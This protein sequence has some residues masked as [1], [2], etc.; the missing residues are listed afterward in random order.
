MNIS[1]K[2]I[3]FYDQFDDLSSNEVA[4]LLK[5]FPKGIIAVDLETTGLSPLVDKIIELS[6]IKVTAAGISTYST[7]INPRIEIPEYTIQ[8]HGITDEMVKD[9]P[10]EEDV[11]GSFIDFCE[12]LPLIGHNAKFDTGFLAFAMGRHQLDLPTS[13]VYCSC[14]M[15]KKAFPNT[16]NHRLGTLVKELDIPLENHHRALDDA[17]ACL[18]LYARSL[19]VSFEKDKYGKMIE[20]SYLFDM[21]DYSSSKSFEIPKTLEGIE[22]KIKNKHL[23]W[24]KYRG[25]SHKNQFRPIRPVSFLPMPGGSVLYAHCLLS[26]LYKSFSLRKIVEWKEMNGADLAEWAPKAGPRD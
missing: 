2:Y 5:Q 16:T 22:D 14:Q 4:A 8:I 15:S 7:L 12:N 13:K 20:Y 11:L 1:T 18:I 23:I 19:E 26:D 3:K 24:I 6:A 17:I 10:F 9:S 25:G 21:G